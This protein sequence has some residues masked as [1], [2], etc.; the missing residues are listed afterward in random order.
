MKVFVHHDGLAVKVDDIK[1]FDGVERNV[2]AARQAIARAT[3][4]DGQ[5]GVGADESGPHLVD[6]AV[7][8]RY[9]QDVE[10]SV[11]GFLG[12]QYGMTSVFR[13]GDLIVEFRQVEMGL[14]LFGEMV[15][16]FLSRDG[17]ND[18][19]YPLFAHGGCR[20]WV[21]IRWKS[22]FGCIRAGSHTSCQRCRGI[23]VGR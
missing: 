10:M 3:R 6:G 8:A 13:Y 18:E 4:D 21:S 23:A 16:V 9:G 17:V 2:Q 1:R 12:Q 22:V 19:S 15:F 11:D 20:R 7:A 5:G 14:N